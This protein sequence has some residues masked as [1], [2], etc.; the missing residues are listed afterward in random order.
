MCALAAGQI[1]IAM[2]ATGTDGAVETADVVLMNDSLNNIALPLDAS[3]RA[4]RI[5]AHD[6]CTV[7]VCLDGL[8]LLLIRADA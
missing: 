2:G 8:R 3:R 6:G 5:V 4:R 7:R 1:G